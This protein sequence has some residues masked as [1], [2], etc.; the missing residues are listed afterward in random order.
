MVTFTSEQIHER[1]RRIAI[2]IDARRQHFPNETP[3]CYQPLVGEEEQNRWKEETRQ[4][5]VMNYNLRDM[6]I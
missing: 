2:G 6:Y 3:Y 5:V 4:K 1:T